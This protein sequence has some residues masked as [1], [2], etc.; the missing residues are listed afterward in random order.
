MNGFLKAPKCVHFC[1]MGK[2]PGHEPDQFME[3]SYKRAFSRKMT[4]EEFR[5]VTQTDFWKSHPNMDEF[6]GN[7]SSLCPDISQKKNE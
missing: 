7:R 6:S 2:F 5:G 1:L 3:N 4:F